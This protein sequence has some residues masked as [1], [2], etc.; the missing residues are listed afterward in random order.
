[1]AQAF[2]KIGFHIVHLPTVDR[3]L[4]REMSEDSLLLY[5]MPH[6]DR[7]FTVYDKPYSAVLGKQQPTREA[8]MHLLT[9]KDVQ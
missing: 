2:P 4:Q 7:N 3:P 5:W 1:L 9:L 6:Y 8:A